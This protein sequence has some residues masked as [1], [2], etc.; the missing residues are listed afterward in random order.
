MMKAFYECNMEAY[1]MKL[2]LEQHI[3][4]AQDI[5]Q[6]VNTYKC[7][8]NCRHLTFSS[9]REEICSFNWNIPRKNIMSNFLMNFIFMKELQL[10]RHTKIRDII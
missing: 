1:L 4:T 8:N 3:D 9:C 5:V 2:D 6:Q 10:L 7:K